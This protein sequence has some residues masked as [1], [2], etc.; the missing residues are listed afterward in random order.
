MAETKRKEQLENSLF[1]KRKRSKLDRRSGEER[2][3]AYDLDY[4][5]LKNGIE[6]RS[7]LERR[8]SNERRSGWMRISKWYSIF[9][10]DGAL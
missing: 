9:I 8:K 10:G 4:F 6:R 5:L 2:R 1:E 7:K 3:K